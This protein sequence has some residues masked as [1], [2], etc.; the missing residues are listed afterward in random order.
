MTYEELDELQ[1]R[2]EINTSCGLVDKDGPSA[3]AAIAQ[4][5]EELDDALDVLSNSARLYFHI[6]RLKL[7]SREQL[8]HL[9]GAQQLIEA[10]RIEGVKA[11]LKAAEKITRGP[12]C[13][14]SSTDWTTG[15]IE[16]GKD[17]RGECNCYEFNE[18]ADDIAALNAAEIVRI[19]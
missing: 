17:N 10:A 13:E 8:L 18:R 2:L 11:G 3:S 9:G 1:K 7:L 14:L 12:L 4:L 6:L 15:A 16:C 19:K 5:R